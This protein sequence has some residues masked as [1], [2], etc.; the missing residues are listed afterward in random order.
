MTIPIPSHGYCG[1]FRV[2]TME[3]QTPGA[4]FWTSHVYIYHRDQSA[5]VA[6]VEGAG[7]AQ[8]RG[9]ARDQAMRIGRKIALTLDPQQYRV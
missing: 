9:D 6:T 2:D 8:Q 4:A 3:V 5:A 7:Q 1:E